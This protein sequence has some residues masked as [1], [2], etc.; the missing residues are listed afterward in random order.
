MARKGTTFLIIAGFVFFLGGCATCRKQNNL[1][2]QG[3]KNQVSLLESQIQSKDEE[4]NSLKEALSK[5]SA[6][7][8]TATQ[9]I[10]KS[11]AVGEVKSRP[12]HKQIQI[13]L[14]NA[15]YYSGSID[16]HIGRLT[17]ESIK[18]FQKA[19]NLSVDGRVGKQTWNL[20]KTYLNKKIK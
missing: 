10:V 15:G 12:N 9:T 7:R 2:L 19:N 17:R 6:E 11:K 18:A 13:A 16:G 5:E 14:L 8:E 4:I 1:E 3:L 20:L